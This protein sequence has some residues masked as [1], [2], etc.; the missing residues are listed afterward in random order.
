MRPPPL[1]IPRLGIDN[2]PPRHPSPSRYFRSPSL[3]ARRRCRTD[4]TK[5]GSARRGQPHHVFSRR[6]DSAREYSLPR[7]RR[8]PDAAC[9]V[10][11]VTAHHTTAA[12]STTAPTAAAALAAKVPTSAARVAALAEVVAPTPPAAAGAGVPKPTMPRAAA[13]VGEGVDE[14]PPASPCPWREEQK[15]RQGGGIRAQ[16]RSDERNEGSQDFKKMR[17]DYK[18]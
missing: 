15:E 3:S 16:W 8:P 9:C 18:R 13:V 17:Q 1:A 14:W 12:N 10:I 2:M 4:E 6:H 11:H 7:R 5:S